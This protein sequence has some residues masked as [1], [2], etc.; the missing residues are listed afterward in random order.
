MLDLI[1]DSIEYQNFGRNLLT[2]SFLATIFLSLA[3]GYGII[4]QFRKIR[5]NKAAGT[6]I[7]IFFVYNCLFCLS[8]FG[9]GL[10]EH[11]LAFIFNG[12]LLG[13]LYI[14]VLIVLYKFKGFTKLD[15]ILSCLG[16]MILPA[17]IFLPNRERVLM[18]SILLMLPT[19]GW[20]FIEFLRT[21]SLG[22]LSLTYVAAFFINSVFWL[23]YSLA[24]H[25]LTMI[26]LNAGTST[27]Y[28][29][30]IILSIKFDSERKKNIENGKKL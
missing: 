8:F 2:F 26:S 16:L 20:Q 30:V 27:L 1:K 9:Y 11:K 15:T 14:P 4:A 5:K 21:K 24:I 28:A 7:N 17:M 3:Q 6:I 13:L 18:V 12:G 29:I 25:N 22:E 19:V 10:L 23:I